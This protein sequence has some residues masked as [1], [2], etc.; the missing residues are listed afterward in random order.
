MGS[1][2]VAGRFGAGLGVV[3][4]RF[5]VR[6]DWEFGWNDG[7]ECQGQARDAQGTGGVAAG[8]AAGRFP[9]AKTGTAPD[10]L[11]VSQFAGEALVFS[12]ECKR[13]SAVRTG[14]DFVEIAHG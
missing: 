12:A 6:S 3:G 10:R 8:T 13:A 14:E 9:G 1:S 4:Y 5:V 2:F 7:H 11:G